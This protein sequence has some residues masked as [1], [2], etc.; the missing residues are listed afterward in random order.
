MQLQDHVTRQL[1]ALNGTADGE[2]LAAV[3]DAYDANG[4]LFDHGGADEPVRGREALRTYWE[5]VMGALPTGRLQWGELVSEGRTV[6][7]QLRLTGRHVG[8]TLYGRP[9]AGN[10]VDLPICSVWRLADDR[11]AVV[12][13]HLYYDGDCLDGQL[14]RGVV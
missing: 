9:P 8:G 1:E 5:Q 14:A 13:H 6:V 11:A 3:C 7:S 10:P 2:G 12:E 4:V